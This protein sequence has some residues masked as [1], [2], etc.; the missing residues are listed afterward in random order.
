MDVIA[1][2]SFFISSYFTEYFY[3]LFVPSVYLI[4]RA[5]LRR[6]RIKTDLKNAVDYCR[7]KAPVSKSITSV[8]LFIVVG[9]SFAYAYEY[10]E[11]FIKRYVPDAASAP[12]GFLVFTGFFATLLVVRLHN[13]TLG[14]RWYISGI[15]LPGE[16]SLLIPWRLVDEVRLEDKSLHI[17]TFGKER[18]YRIKEEDLSSADYFVRWFYKKK[19]ATE[20]DL[21]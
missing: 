5:I 8:I 7:I 11:G 12:Y 20:S 6:N 2:L 3:H 9:M 19:N 10:L 16:R 4:V 14:V 21:I 17:T 15:K 1:W 13:F 18:I